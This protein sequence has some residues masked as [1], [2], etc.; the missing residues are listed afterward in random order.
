MS[1]TEKLSIL[2]RKRTTLR[3]AITKLSTKLNYLNCTQADIEFNAERLQIKFNELTLTDDEINDFLNDQEYSEDII[4]CEKYSENAHL[5]LFNSKKKANTSA[6]ILPCSRI[7]SLPTSDSIHYASPPNVTINLPTVNI[8][9][10]YGKIEEFHS[11]WERFE[12]CIDKNESLSQIDKQVFL[13]GY[14]DAEAKRL[15]DGISITADTYTMTKEI[16][17]SKYGNKDKIIQ[18]HL[19]YLENLTPIKDLSPSALNEMYIDCNKRLQALDALDEKTQSYERILAPKILRAFP[20]EICRNWVVY[21]KRENLAE[22]DIANLMK[23]LSEEVEGTITANNIKG[24]LV[25]SYPIKSSLENFN[26]HSRPINARIQKLK[27]TNRCFL[28]TNRGHVQK[29]CFRKEKYRCSKCRKKHHVSICKTPTNEQSATTSTN[30]IDTPTYNFVHLQTARVFITGLN[31]I[32]KLTRCL[33]DG[34][35]QSSFISSD[36]VDTLN[37]PIIST[38]PL[39]L[40]A[41]ESPT[42]FSHKRWQVQFQL[43]SIWDKAKANVIAFENSNRYASHPSSPTDVSRFAKNK[44]M[45]LADP[46]DPLSSLPIEILIGADFYWNVMH[47]DAPFK[48]SDSLALVPSSFGWILSGSRSHATVSFNPT[49]HSINVDTFTHELDNMVRN[50]WNLESIGI[51]PIQEKLRL[52]THNAELL[53]NFHQSFKIIDGRRVVHLPWKPEVKLTKS[54]YD[55]AI[56]RFNYWTRRIHT[57]TELKQKYAKQMQDY[58]DKNKSKP[59]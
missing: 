54:N 48:L 12:N 3:T 28:C 43:S 31:G 9:T 22:S 27:A 30:K 23:F 8:N 4:E 53:T 1:T 25:P 55:T 7:G 14:L 21:T 56:H 35:S 36:L 49:V 41:F 46:D 51:Q 5:L 39:D 37:L 15:V 17:K 57:N 10:F 52:S 26:V 11:F 29:N 20:H 42:N 33:L 18:A 44:R 38:A 24:S 50:F 19:D 59:S 34:G 45:K 32:T 40:Q 47:S 2:K 13:R 16:L 58:I 6:A